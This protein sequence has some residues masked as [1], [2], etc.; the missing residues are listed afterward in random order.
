[1]FLSYYQRSSLRL[2]G[3]GPPHRRMSVLPTRENM[4]ELAI[5]TTR[6]AQS[7][8]V[9]IAYQV[10][11]DGPV[12]LILVPGI[13]PTSSSSTKFQ[14]IRTTSAVLQPSHVSLNSTS[15]GRDCPIGCPACHHSNS[16]WTT[17]RPSWRR[18]D[19]NARHCWDIPKAPR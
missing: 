13:D 19:R 16:G 11:G 4:T 2:I 10:M 9:S 1:M 8:E 15:V 3:L 18:S 7:G 12:D 6:Y 5:P 17:W 14:R